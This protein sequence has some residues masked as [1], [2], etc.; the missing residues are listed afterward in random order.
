[1]P[2]FCPKKFPTVSAFFRLSSDE[3][4]LVVAE[5]KQHGL[6]V[7]TSLLASLTV[8][9]AEAASEYEKASEHA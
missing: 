9:H 7:A 2:Y 3:Q 6:T 1:M 5:N 8:A 4:C